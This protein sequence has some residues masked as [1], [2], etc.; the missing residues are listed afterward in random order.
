MSDRAK[1]G[2][3][4]ESN[5]RCPLCGNII[6]SRIES[7]RTID[8]SNLYRRVYKKDIGYIWKSVER[9]EYVLCQKCGLRFFDPIISGDDD[10][11]N[12]LLKDE[13]YYLHEGKTEYDYSRKF[14]EEDDRVLDIGAG[15]GAFRHYLS[16]KN[17]YQGLDLSSKAIELAKKDGANVLPIPIE[18]FSEENK[19]RFDVV[20]I[21]QVIEHISSL[22]KFM[23]S[24]IDC[25][26]KGGLLIVATPDND[27]FIKYLSNFCLNLPPYHTLHWN[28][29]SLRSMAE[30]YNLEVLD[31]YREP[32]SSVHRQWWYNTMSTTYLNR[33]LRRD[34]RMIDYRFTYK[35]VRLAA[36]ILAQFYK[37]SGEHKKSFG[38]SIIMVCRKPDV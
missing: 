2:F 29:R 28:E 37:L 15:R 9:L 25:I 13:W 30:K 22:D 23:C 36:K 26:V 20:S 31:I 11:Y 18:E 21:F 10:F 7:V 14:I 6:K 17:Y 4:R 19:E 8:I 33:L 27:G 24:A 3:M 38:Q 5:C 1:L 16:E 12:I 35:I 34:F 32:V